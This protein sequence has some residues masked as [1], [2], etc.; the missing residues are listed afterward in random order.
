MSEG[1]EKT[2]IEGAMNIPGA[3]TF[4][5]AILS[6]APIAA[7]YV[8]PDVEVKKI[9]GKDYAH[10]EEDEPVIVSPMEFNRLQNKAAGSEDIA[11]IRIVF[12]GKWHKPAD[13]LAKERAAALGANCLVLQES[14]GIE[15]WGAGTIR[16][17]KAVRLTNLTGRPIYTKPS[18]E[19]PPANPSTTAP[20][21]PSITAPAMP[22]PPQET[23][24]TQAQPKVHRHF[25][26]V[27]EGGDHIL[28]HRLGF[29][30]SRA[31]KE[32]LEQLSLYVRENFP[33]PEHG[34][35]LRAY[36]KRSKIILDFRNWT[37]R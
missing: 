9:S 1:H 12:K 2:H 18:D 31:K 34:K 25:A 29:D 36:K 26:W 32:E 33:A 11:T 27:W 24:P 5:I 19:P 37:L 15:D 21:S 30:A 35:L 14:I 20:A 7:Q 23:P 22:T 17:Y 28:S 3:I 13:H 16:A 10:E 6:A 4:S 8:E